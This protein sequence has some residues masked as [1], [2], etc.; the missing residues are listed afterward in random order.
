MK[1]QIFIHNKQDDVGIAVTE[2]S[3]NMKAK[4]KVLRSNDLI[5]KEVKVKENIPLPHKI[6]LKDIKKGKEVTEYGRTIGVAKEDIK[7]GEHVHIHNLK[8]LKA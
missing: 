7:T 2:L 8:S 5:E 1:Y 6:A 3:A 4:A